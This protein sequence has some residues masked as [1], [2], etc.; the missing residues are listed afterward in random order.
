MSRSGQPSSGTPAAI[1]PRGPR[2]N[3]SVL[4]LVLFVGF[5]ADLWLV[6]PV[7]GACL[8]LGA[9][10]QPTWNPT[11]WLYRNYVAPRLG[12]PAYREDPR[13]PRFSARIGALFLGGATLAFS[14]GASTAGWVLT[15]IVATL[16]TLAATT[17]ICLGCELYL[18]LPG[19]RLHRSQ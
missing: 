14:L 18:L 13:P 10:G 6:A 3:Q 2:F 8:A 5:A 9:W 1:D 12:Q 15:L 4:A 17:G 19:N 11:F 7:M 16:A